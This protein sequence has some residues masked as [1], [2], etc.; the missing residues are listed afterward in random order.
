MKVTA[1]KEPMVQF[2]VRNTGARAGAEDRAQD[3][4]GVHADRGDLATAV[5]TRVTGGVVRCRG[6]ATA[7]AEVDRHVVRALRA[8]ARYG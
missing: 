8:T 5:G 6:E 7:H 2:T 3:A 1:G 4:T